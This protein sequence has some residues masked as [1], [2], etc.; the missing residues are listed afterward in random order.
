MNSYARR[1]PRRTSGA[2][3]NTDGLL[4]YAAAQGLSCALIEDRDGCPEVLVGGW[5]VM[6]LAEVKRLPVPG[7][8]KPSE[9]ALRERQKKWRQRWRGPAPLLW[10]TRKDVDRTVKEMR[11]EAAA[12]ADGLLLDTVANAPKPA[13]FGSLHEEDLGDQREGET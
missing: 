13:E 6:R 8:V 1:P 11:A 3:T 7:K 9:A 10:R 4:K 12:K 5:G 2:D